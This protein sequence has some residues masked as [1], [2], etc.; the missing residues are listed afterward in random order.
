MPQKETKARRALLNSATILLAANPG[1]TFIQIAENANIGR[2]TLYRHFSTREDLIRTLSLEAIHAIDAASDA[3]TK[4]T[5]DPVEILR[6]SLKAII[7]LGDRYYFLIRLPDTENDEITKHLQRQDQELE[8]LIQQAQK[9]GSID[10]TAPS[11]WLCS[12]Y[13]AI[14]YAAWEQINKN[15]LE[16]K[17]II[18]LATQS[19]NKVFVG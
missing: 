17:E 3:V 16:E 18:Q 12:L 13:N 8:Y 2:A 4:E 1:A 14:F 19:F 5:T 6:L 11:T 7:P 9:Q 15:A 10:P